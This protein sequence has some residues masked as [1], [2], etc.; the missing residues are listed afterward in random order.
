M[1]ILTFRTDKPEAE[2]GLFEDGNKLAYSIW[3]AHRQLAETI[4][5]KISELLASQGRGLDDLDGLVVFKGPG[6]FTG[7]RIGISVA[8]ALAYSLQIPIVAETGERWL[9]QGRQAL[10]KGK[11]QRIAVPE[12]GSPPHITTPRK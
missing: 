2:L 7:L 11:N 9:E 6:S 1:L 12:Y 8:N 4:H 10:N 3:P 5:L